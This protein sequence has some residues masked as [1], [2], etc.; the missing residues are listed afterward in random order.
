M[1]V[2]ITPV[3]TANSSMLDHDAV[4]PGYTCAR[5]D[6]DFPSS[7]DFIP[8]CRH[9]PSYQDMWEFTQATSQGLARR[10]L[11][12]IRADNDPHVQYLDGD[13]L[14]CHRHRILRG[15]H[16]CL[17]PFVHAVRFVAVVPCTY[18]DC[19]PPGPYKKMQYRKITII[20]V[21]FTPE[22]YST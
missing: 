7:P 8:S 1:L 21:E 6:G 9:S 2:S 4:I 16:R 10:V 5:D 3:L 18:D 12:Y 19:D 13:I 22:G 17:R 14:L 11:V 20:H 15:L